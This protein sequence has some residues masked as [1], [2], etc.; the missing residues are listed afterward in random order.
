MVDFAHLIGK[1]SPPPPIVPRL[2]VG[3]T[4]H[5]PHKLPDPQTGYD[6]GNPLRRRLRDEMRR[7]VG[8]LVARPPLV[9]DRFAAMHIDSYLRQVEWKPGFAVTADT[10]LAFSGVALGVDQDFCGVCTR[11]SPSVPYVAVVPFPGQESRWPS[12]R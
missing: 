5:R 7:V 9:R 11:L 10:V 12:G 2:C 1:P 4:G 8:E 3:I 6:W